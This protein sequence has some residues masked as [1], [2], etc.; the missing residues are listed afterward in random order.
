MHDPSSIFP[1]A[2][3]PAGQATRFSVGDWQADASLD[4]LQHA[5]GRRQKLEPRAMR[6]LATLAQRPGELFTSAQLMLAVWPGLVVTPASLYEA[7]AQLRK[8]LGPD[9]LATVPRKG[10]RLTAR[11]HGLAAAQDNEMAPALGPHAIAVLPFRQQGLTGQHA[12]LRDSLADA[13]ISELSRQPGLAV[14]SRGTMLH[15]D[16]AAVVPQQVAREL[17]VQQVV[18]G[19]LGLHGETLEITVQ[20]VDGQRGT[21]R[22]AD[23]VSLPLARWPDASGLVVGR[24]ARALN[25]EL[26]D[27]LAHTPAPTTQPGLQAWTLATRAWVELFGKPEG[28]GVNARAANWAEAALVLQSPLPLASI[29]LAFCHWRAAQFGWDDTPREQLLACALAQAEAA[30]QH[31]PQEPDAHYVHALIAYSQGETA[32]AEEGLRHCLRLSNSHAPAHGLLA[33]IRTRRG[34]PQETAALCERAFALSPREPLR[35]VWHLA[36]AW[37]ALAMADFPAALEASQQ[38]MAVNAEFATA[39]LTGTAAAQQLGATAL[40]QRWVTFLRER[41]AFDSLAAVQARLPPATEPAHR[42]Q[43]VQLLAL[44]RAAGLPPR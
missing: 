16:P 13:L 9:H 10:Y 3:R 28:P 7:A 43:M 33:L 20:V 37:A 35:V 24:L 12:F 32:R 29:C 5:D 4:Q 27:L 44:L 19:L 30:L 42:Q 31:G 14:I 6:L 41:S 22:W 18:E 25:L 40:V 21:Q 39:Y 15:Y 2:S 38:A 11:V 23:S 17:G 34:H 26:R 36:L 1:P 8:A